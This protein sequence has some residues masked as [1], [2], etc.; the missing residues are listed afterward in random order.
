MERKRKRFGVQLRHIDE[1]FSVDGIY[2]YLIGPYDLC[3]S[4]GKPGDFK[5]KEGI[6]VLKTVKEAG[7][8]HRIRAGYHVIERDPQEVL[9]KKKEGYKIIAVSTDMLFLLRK[10]ESVFKIIQ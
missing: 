2:G 7:I 6:E 10:I 1:I 8:K 4:L 9:N 5:C 3:A